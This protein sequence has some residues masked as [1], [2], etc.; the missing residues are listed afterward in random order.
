MKV[1]EWGEEGKKLFIF[2]RSVY[3]N[4]SLA[5]DVEK[6]QFVWKSSVMMVTPLHNAVA[7]VLRKSSPLN[8]HRAKSI[9]TACLPTEFT[10]PKKE[11]P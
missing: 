8:L 7:V 5:L 11:R 3:L 10:V 4:S 1:I 6:K 9:F 2:Q